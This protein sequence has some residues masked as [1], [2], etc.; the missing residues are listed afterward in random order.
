M[1]ATPSNESRQNSPDS[2]TAL[3]EFLSAYLE[4]LGTRPDQFR[5]AFIQAVEQRLIAEAAD[6]FLNRQER[7]PFEDFIKWDYEIVE[8]YGD[9]MAIDWLIED[10]AVNG[11]TFGVIAPTNTGASTLIVNMIYSL[12]S[13]K[14][15]LNQFMPNREIVKADPLAV[16][17]NPEEHE[18]LPTQRLA[19]LYGEETHEKLLHLTI[20]NQ[21]YLNEPDDA[22]YVAE[23]VVTRIGA[24]LGKRPIVLVIDGY[25]PTNSEDPWNRGFE[26][27]KRGVRTVA[28]AVGGPALTVVRS[29]TTTAKARSNRQGVE[30]K[31][32]DAIGQFATYPDTRAVYAL[33]TGNKSKLDQDEATKAAVLEAINTDSGFGKSGP[34]RLMIYDRFHADG[35][36]PNL[37]V[38]F[39]A[40]TGRLY[41]EEGD[42][43]Q[44]AKAIKYLRIWI[45][46][47]DVPDQ[48][49]S[50]NRLAKA[51]RS[52][53]LTE[54]VEEPP[55]TSTIR[56]VIGE[57]FQYDADRGWHELAKAEA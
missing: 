36:G 30:V 14:P 55:G 12:G 54:D 31:L 29:Q 52:Y 17:L 28:N 37:V 32:T 9:I 26:R 20:G 4:Q 6:K 21:F 16:W 1:T 7:P 47:T 40:K 53:M 44:K 38:H 35:Q 50:A 41:A 19:L 13:G 27:W 48:P 5:N 10:V 15:F 57:R 34:R 3:D 43:S 18:V 51:V 33:S 39:D 8:Q 22:A 49:T 56:E 23:G 46:I 25:T 24:D 11:S 2:V 45:G 42:L